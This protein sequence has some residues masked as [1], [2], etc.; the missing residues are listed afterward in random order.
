MTDFKRATHNVEIKQAKEIVN[1]LQTF[2]T[3]HNNEIGTF[4]HS[5]PECEK[6]LTQYPYTPDELIDRLNK[7]IDVYERI[8][9]PQSIFDFVVDPFFDM[10]AIYVPTHDV[11]IETVIQ[12]LGLLARYSL[13]KNAEEKEQIITN[14]QK[15]DANYAVALTKYNFT[16]DVLI[17][18]ITQ[19]IMLNKYRP[20]NMEFADFVFSS[21]SDYV[22]GDFDTFDRELSMDIRNNESADKI[23]DKFNFAT[24]NRFMMAKQFANDWIRRLLKH[25][26]L[27]KAAHM[28]T[29]DK[30][31]AI[32]NKLFQALIND[33]CDEYQM[34][35]NTI[36]VQVVNKWD[37]NMH[38]KT[39]AFHQTIL[40]R[41]DNLGIL[42][43]KLPVSK[44]R[45]HTSAEK[46]SLIVLNVTKIRNSLKPKENLFDKMVS[47]FAHEIHHGLDE[48][49]PRFGALGSQI[50]EI[51]NKIY[52][53]SNTKSY[54]SSATERSSYEIERQ[55]LAALRKTRI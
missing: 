24:V 19:A 1:L 5:H 7:A 14:L 8:P 29:F 15:L 48:L 40:P 11:E 49:K 17:N 36:K 4:L 26:K 25:P 27:V 42:N 46:T 54:M 16:P 31:P 13:A 45:P 34:P 41:T 30:Q 21:D 51:D 22:G 6:L 2:K 18:R 10:D 33:F 35:R 39:D 44:L 43:K 12:C 23:R 53:I 52:D 55:L 9:Q 28:A 32:Y 38:L 37:D 3:L 50:K 20:K 47:I